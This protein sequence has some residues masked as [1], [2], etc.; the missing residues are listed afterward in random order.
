MLN[1][2][3]LLRVPQVDSLFDISPDNTKLAFAWNK[4]GEWQIYELDLS[5]A[6]RSVL[7]LRSSQKPLLTPLRT[8]TPGATS[9]DE[10][11]TIITST[12]GGKFNLPSS[13]T[14]RVC[15]RFRRQ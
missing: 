15:F 8:M 11:H 6:E 3:D 14:T 4:T 13:E 12:T 1:L 2:T 10:A 5:R 7:R 9:E